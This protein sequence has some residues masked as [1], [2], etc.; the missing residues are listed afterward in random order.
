MTSSPLGGTTQHHEND[1]ADLCSS[2]GACSSLLFQSSSS[3]STS[4][5]TAITKTHDGQHQ[6]AQYGNC[7]HHQLSHGQYAASSSDY[8]ASMASVGRVAHGNNNNSVIHASSASDD[9]TAMA[10][11][12]MSPGEATLETT[13]EAA[14]NNCRPSAARGSGARKRTPAEKVLRRKN[15][16]A[17][18]LT[19]T[20]PRGMRPGTKKR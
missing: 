6:Q 18:L 14:A 7:S 17:I 16:P 2:L 10:A 13:G 5:T 4:S 20:P 3:S 1:D 19:S 11:M 15:T 12:A 9:P 8:S